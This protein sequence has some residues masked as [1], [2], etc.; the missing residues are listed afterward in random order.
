MWKV[1]YF[2]LVAIGTCSIQAT[3][4]RIIGGQDATR[5]QFPFQVSL[6]QTTGDHFCGG[7]IIAS[8]FILSSAQCMH[9]VTIRTVLVFVGAHSRTDGTEYK[10]DRITTHPNFNWLRKENDIAV[11]RTDKPMTFNDF[12]QAI[13]LP[14][15]NHG[16]GHLTIVSGWGRRSVSDISSFIC[17]HFRRIIYFSRH[18]SVSKNGDGNDSAAFPT[19][20]QWKET[21]TMS[22][23]ECREVLTSLGRFIHSNNVCTSNRRGQGICDQDYGGP[24]IT[25]T[26]PRQLVGIAS[27]VRTPCAGAFPDMYSAVYQHL[28]FIRGAMQ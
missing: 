24:L 23:R 6:R 16:A 21:R 9:D 19:T 14:T 20:L 11:L 17:I 18:F 26:T 7:A 4:N 5:G 12:V 8:R 25:S 2:L 27:W 15:A 22:V 10:L 13:A 3:E 28:T 1:I